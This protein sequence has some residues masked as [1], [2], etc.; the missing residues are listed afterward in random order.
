MPGDLEV[1]EN[2]LKREAYYHKIFFVIF[3][4]LH[5]GARA[6]VRQAVGMPDIVVETK[7]YIYIIEVKI[8]STPKVALRQIEEQHYA[9]PYLTDG[10]KVIKLGVNFSTA[11]RTIDAWEMA[12]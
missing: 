2:E 9:A 8:N 10:R 7:Q 5:N 3:S 4:M 1:L 11:T 6:Q 12:E